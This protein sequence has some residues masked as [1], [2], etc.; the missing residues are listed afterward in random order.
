[1]DSVRE[2]L[3]IFVR[4]FGLLNASCC[5]ACCG[6]EVS[7]VQSHILFEVRRRGNPSMQQ[8][9]EELGI[10]VTTFSRQIKTLEG[11]GL[12]ARRQS[13]RDRRVSLLE[14]T[15]AGEESMTRIDRYM[16]EKMRQ[17]FTVMT[18]FEQEVVTSSLTLLNKAL[19]RV[20]TDPSHGK[21]IA[22][23]N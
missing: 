13:E 12:V 10:D 4:R 1:M 16:E 23:C 20:A 17:L 18:P 11:R 8:V 9:A 7:L 15:G 22:C 2:Q 3:H 19:A 6:E 21:T 5:E 14:L